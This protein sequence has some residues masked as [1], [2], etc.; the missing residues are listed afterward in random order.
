MKGQLSQ[1]TFFYNVFVF[2]NDKLLLIG[3]RTFF[4]LFLKCKC[5]KHKHKFNPILSRTG[6]A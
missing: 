3:N 4:Y 5:L 2:N 6:R 1:C